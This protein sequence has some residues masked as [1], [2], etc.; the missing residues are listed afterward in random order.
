MFIIFRGKFGLW[1]DSEFY[2]GRS[3][4]C[5]IYNSEMLFVIEDFICIG[6]EVWVF[7]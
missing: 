4:V 7:G 6:V 3:I 5:D 1:L 2:Y